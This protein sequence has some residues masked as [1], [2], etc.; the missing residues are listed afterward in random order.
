MRGISGVIGR[1]TVST[2]SEGRDGDGSVAC[3]ESG[4]PKEDTAIPKGD[5]AGGSYGGN[6]YRECEGGIGE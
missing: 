4:G 1:D 2:N 6:G 5:G 3:A